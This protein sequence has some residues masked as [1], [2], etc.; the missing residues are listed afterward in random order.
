MLTV[1]VICIGKLKEQYL[2]DASTEYQ[3]R[4]NAFCKLNVIELNEYRISDNPSK[5]EIQNCIEKEGFLI[6]SKIPKDSFVVPLCIEG[7]E[8][9]STELST[10]IEKI[11]LSGQSSI[12]FIIGSS[13]GLSDDV[14]NC[15]K[16]KLSM[17]RMTFPHQLAR[18][19]LLEQ[20]YRCFQIISNGKYH[21]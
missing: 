3:K 13:Y 1:N 2:R 9:S 11:S 14:K 6:K 20:I 10:E 17:S 18:V 15:G 21:K 12:T 16:L 4:L 19:M 5:T 8:F 7:R